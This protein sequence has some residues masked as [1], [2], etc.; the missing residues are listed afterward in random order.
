M[1]NTKN[2]IP[3]IWAIGGGKG[4]V[5][6]SVIATNMAV[7]LAHR[8]LRVALVDTDFGGGNLHTLLGVS[9]PR[10]TL[11]DF[12]AKSV[13]NLVDTLGKTGVENLFLVSGARAVL[14]AANLKYAQK[15]KVLRH[16]RKLPA[17]VVLLDLGAGSSFNVLD[18]FIAADLGLLVAK[19]EHT[20]VENAY[21][22]LKAAYYRRLGQSPQTNP[23]KPLFDRLMK[24]REEYGIRS[25][26]DLVRVAGR[27]DPAA[28]KAIDSAL[29]GFSPTITVNQTELPNDRKLPGQMA[30]AVRE[31]FGIPTI[32]AVAIPSDRLLVRSVRDRRPA[33][34]LF[35]GA[36]FSQAIDELVT[37]LLEQMESRDAGA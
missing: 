3:S 19:P 31:Y 16:I 4:G 32:A 10:W 28:G 15:Q 1:S 11:S 23:F 13:P 21:Q 37:G 36:P 5:G 8:G 12:L 26:Q 9:A 25:P 7:T 2:S 17:D 22:F 14:D 30:G 6:K 29:N 20:S 35:P 18:F 27:L 33:V 34:E 24:N